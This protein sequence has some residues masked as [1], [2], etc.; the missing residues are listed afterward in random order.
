MDA[1][2]TADAAEV[3]GNGAAK[4]AGAAGTLSKGQKERLRKKAKAAAAAEAAR[5]GTSEPE[6]SAAVG[7]SQSGGSGSQKPKGS[8]GHLVAVAAT[9]LVVSGS[10]RA[11]ARVETE[12]GEGRDVGSGQAKVKAKTIVGESL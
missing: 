10:V 12:V 3:A 5:S 7:G 1:A 9:H 8:V 11:G 6:L 2:E 4:P